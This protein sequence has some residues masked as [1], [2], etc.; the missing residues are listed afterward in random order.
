MINTVETRISGYSD[1]QLEG[2]RNAVT[3]QMIRVGMS[4]DISDIFAHIRLFSTALKAVGS[5]G[6]VKEDAT[7]EDVQTLVQTR[8]NLRRYELLGEIDSK[9]RWEQGSRRVGLR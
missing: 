3:G 8:Q 2:V 9:L 1:A 5:A 4:F 6:I 7:F